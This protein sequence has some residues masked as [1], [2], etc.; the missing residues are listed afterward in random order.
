MTG[1]AGGRI[2]VASGLAIVGLAVFVI[3]GTVQSPRGH[4]SHWRHLWGVSLVAAAVVNILVYI[5]IVARGDRDSV[6]L[7]IAQELGTVF[8]V[9]WMVTTLL[10]ARRGTARQRLAAVSGWWN[11][12]PPRLKRRRQAAAPDSKN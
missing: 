1:I 3:L 4:V 2:Q 5:E 8:L 11:D 12:E 6:I 9:L 7:P 10:E